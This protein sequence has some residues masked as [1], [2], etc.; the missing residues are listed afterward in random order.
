MAS[1]FSTSTLTS[2]PLLVYVPAPLTIALPPSSRVLSMLGSRSPVISFSCSVLFGRSGGL[3]CRSKI[4]F[5]SRSKPSLALFSAALGKAYASSGERSFKSVLRSSII[6]RLV[7]FL[8]F[9]EP[10][11]PNSLYSCCTMDWSRLKRS[12]RGVA[13]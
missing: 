13:V 7:C 4:D 10:F 8:A 11:R 6:S 1:C 2:G 9:N 5:S 3:L 12:L